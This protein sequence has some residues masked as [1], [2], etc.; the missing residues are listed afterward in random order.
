MLK[1][2]IKTGKGYL[3]NFNSF[4]KDPIEAKLFTKAGVDKMLSK[5]TRQVK[6]QGADTLDA[7]LTYEDL[8]VIP[9]TLAFEE[10]IPVAVHYIQGSFIFSVGVTHV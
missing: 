2:L 1:Y 4:T 8:R 7:M 3:V 6:P 5:I 10:E 9:V